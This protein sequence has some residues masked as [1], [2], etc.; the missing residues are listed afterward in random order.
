MKI[1]LKLDDQKRPSAAGREVV[2]LSVTGNRSTICRFQ[3]ALASIISRASQKPADALPPADATALEQMTVMGY[4]RA[5][6]NCALVCTDNDLGAA[7]QWLQDH[8]HQRDADLKQAARQHSERTAA[9]QYDALTTQ[10]S[11]M[12]YSPGAIQAAR[13]ASGSTDVGE[14][15]EWLSRHPEAAAGPAG[16]LYPPPEQATTYPVPRYPA[17]EFAAG[18]Q[19]LPDAGGSLQSHPVLVQGGGSGSY[20]EPDMTMQNPYA[21]YTGNQSSGGSPLRPVAA[22]SSRPAGMEGLVAVRRAQAS[23]IGADV[24]A[25]FKD[26]QVRPPHAATPH[27]AMMLWA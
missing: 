9:A 7:I 15:V 27:G 12:G 8:S 22:V 6:A 10:L 5:R 23:R 26:L 14:L 2:K 1:M 24:Q 18:P 25:G 3:E 20:P 21:L 13:A 17:P 19:S 16:T 4:A 11:S